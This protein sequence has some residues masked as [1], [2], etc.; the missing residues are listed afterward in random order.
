L[1]LT[2]EEYKVLV[3]IANGLRSV[4]EI[5][6]ATKLRKEN[7]RACEESLIEKGLIERKGF[8]FFS[9]PSTL[10]KGLEAITTYR[11]VYGE[12]RDTK[13]NQEAVNYEEG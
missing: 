10:E 3:A 6:E 9:E 11:Q 5:A 8:L 13:Q 7:V 4:E 2:R 12:G 1:P